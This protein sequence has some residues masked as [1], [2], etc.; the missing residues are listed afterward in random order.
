MSKGDERKCE[1]HFAVCKCSYGLDRPEVNT[2]FC[3]HIFKL[4]EWIRFDKFLNKDFAGESYIFC[5]DPELAVT[6]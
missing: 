3:L 5:L 4:Q 6:H 2:K 1:L